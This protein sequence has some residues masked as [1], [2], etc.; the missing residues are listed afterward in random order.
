MRKRE[1]SGVHRDTHH[2][3]GKQD[4]VRCGHNEKG[5]QRRK[6]RNR[7]EGGV[8]EEANAGKGLARRRTAGIRQ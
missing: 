8:S 7:R 5:R 6:G 3:H 2:R 4:A 1:G